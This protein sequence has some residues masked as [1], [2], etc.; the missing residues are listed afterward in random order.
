[1][2]MIDAAK[3]KV[4]CL[5]LLKK[6]PAEGIMITKHGK[7]VARLM[8]ASSNCADLIGSMK[9]KIQIHGEICHTGVEWSA[10]S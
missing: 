1:M 7:P 9:D 3:F 10:E 8:P 4:Q 2:K 5:E 6:L